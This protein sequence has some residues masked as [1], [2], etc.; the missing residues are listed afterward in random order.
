MQACTKPQ[1]RTQSV[2]TVRRRHGRAVGMIG[3]DELLRLADFV[4]GSEGGTNEMV[5][6]KDLQC[7]NAL[8][9]AVIEKAHRIFGDNGSRDRAKRFLRR[10]QI[11]KQYLQNSNG[12]SSNNA[13]E[14]GKM[15]QVEPMNSNVSSGKHGIKRGSDHVYHYPYK[16]QRSEFTA[17]NGKALKK[18]IIGLLMT[19]YYEISEKDRALCEMAAEHVIALSPHVNTPGVLVKNAYEIFVKLKS[20]SQENCDGHEVLKN[21]V[22]DLMVQKFGATYENEQVMCRA[23]VDQAIQENPSACVSPLLLECASEIYIQKQIRMQI[24]GHHFSSG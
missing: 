2:C 20:L 16:E 15:E 11:G 21:N 10:I 1:Q 24:P 19:D 23:A 18:G 3:E 9:A 12:D 17:N 13:M 6:P 5:I 22:V 4:N 8:L 14:H 7:N